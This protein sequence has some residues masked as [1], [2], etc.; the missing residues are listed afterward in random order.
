DHRRFRVHRAAADVADEIA[1]ATAARDPKIVL[2][3]HALHRADTH[4]EHLPL[5]GFVEAHR[6]AVGLA[7]RPLRE[8]FHFPE[9]RLELRIVFRGGGGHDGEHESDGNVLHGPTI[10]STNSFTAVAASRSGSSATSR[11]T[12]CCF[13][14]D[15]KSTRLN[16]SHVSISYA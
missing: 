15:R 1:G 6:R 4:F 12:C 5:H 3:A 10:K 13:A 16:S 8:T 9:A 11:I 14:A 2:A 7:R